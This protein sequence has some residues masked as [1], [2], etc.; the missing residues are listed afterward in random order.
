MR[1]DAGAKGIDKVRPFLAEKYVVALTKNWCVRLTIDGILPSKLPTFPSDSSMAILINS[2]CNSRDS[3]PDNAFVD[4]ALSQRLHCGR[5]I[6]RPSRLYTSQRPVAASYMGGRIDG[7]N[8]EAVYHDSLPSGHLAEEAIP[9][10]FVLTA[11]QET[12]RVKQ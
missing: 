7:P 11:Q 3:Y 1:T 4:A 5:K 8:I 12:A 9:L 2:T 10:P 6:A